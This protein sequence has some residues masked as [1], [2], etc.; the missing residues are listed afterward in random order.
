MPGLGVQAGRYVLR[1]CHVLLCAQRCVPEC[2]LVWLCVSL[3]LTPAH[4][5]NS[6]LPVG[7]CVPVQVSD[8][9][10]WGY[11]PLPP[12]LASHPHPSSA[13][14]SLTK[15]CFA[16]QGSAAPGKASQMV[17][18]AHPPG[19]GTTS[20]VTTERSEEGQPYDY[21][22][23]DL[24][25]KASQAPGRG[26]QE[27]PRVVWSREEGPAGRHLGSRVTCRGTC[28]RARTTQRDKHAQVAGHSGEDLRSQVLWRRAGGWQVGATP[29]KPSEN[30]WNTKG[31]AAQ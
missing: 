5:G 4:L 21:A 11:W 15:E 14:V 30:D 8:T 1:V 16:T 18:Q 9:S 7:S 24:L 22:Q 13:L 2:V 25:H 29:G 20:F 17:T 26:A 19:L 23:E 31:W 3:V 10:P 27:K 28:C 6:A 12:G